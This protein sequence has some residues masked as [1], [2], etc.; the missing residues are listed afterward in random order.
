MGS[1]RL[2]TKKVL[3]IILRDRR[4]Y[5]AYVEPFV[6]GANMIKT[7]AGMLRIASDVNPYVIQAI[8]SIRD[9]S[10]LLPKNNKEFTENDYNKLKLSDEYKYKGFAG[11]SYSFGGKWLGGW[12]RGKKANGIS[13]DYV[14]ENYRSAQIQSKKIQGIDFKCCSYAELKIP[15]NS[16]IYCD[17]PYRDTTKYKT[18]QN[19]DH[20]K[21]YRWCVCQSKKGH[22]VFVSEYNMPADFKLVWK[23]KILCFLDK[24]KKSKSRSRTEKL[25][26]AP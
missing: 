25:F 7:V 19:F 11:F 15:E 10:E 12:A 13:R 16:L 17:P 1:K 5:S 20:E 3:P 18:K 21:F 23:S 24:S 2:Y 8:T 14:A 22:T 26:V 9:E 6:G 4:K